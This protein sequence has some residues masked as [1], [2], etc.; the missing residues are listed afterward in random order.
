MTLRKTLLAGLAAI[1]LTTTGCGAAG[2][3]TFTKAEL[4]RHTAIDLYK[5][6]CGGP[7]DEY[8]EHRLAVWIAAQQDAASDYGQAIA[9]ELVKAMNDVI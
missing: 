6:L 2:L 9:D 4:H 3:D 7:I 8:E 1:A 5:S